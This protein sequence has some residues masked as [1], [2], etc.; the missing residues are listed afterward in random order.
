LG[1]CKKGENS[2]NICLIAKQDISG[3]ETLQLR[4]S[5][6]QTERQSFKKGISLSRMDRC[7]DKMACK[8]FRRALNLS[9]IPY[10]QRGRMSFLGKGHG[11]HPAKLALFLLLFL[12]NSEMA[13][14]QRPN[15][16]PEKQINEVLRTLQLNPEQK[17]KVQQ[18]RE[19]SRKS[20]QTLR[21]DLDKRRQELDAQLDN[22]GPDEA[23]RQAFQNLQKARAALEKARFERMLA[24]RSVLSDQQKEAFQNL[25]QTRRAGHRKHGPVD[26]RRE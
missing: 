4:Q 5:Q 25:R 12:W 9:P 21:D 13:W 14:A 18:I 11:M 23:L 3:C 19:S 1:F 6:I 20:M 24:I 26:I 22:N 16:H 8:I 17:L 10:V 2:K 15:A 7:Y